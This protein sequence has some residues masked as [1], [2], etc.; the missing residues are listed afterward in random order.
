[1][2]YIILVQSISLDV[3]SVL[4]YMFVFVFT[5]ATQSE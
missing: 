4:R 3:S 1:M 2:I 5:G